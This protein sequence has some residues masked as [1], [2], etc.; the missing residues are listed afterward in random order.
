[1]ITH[2]ESYLDAYFRFQRELPTQQEEINRMVS[3]VSA[4]TA[5]ALNFVQPTLSVFRQI[6]L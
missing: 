2:A 3:E 5:R 6:A 1:M 4:K